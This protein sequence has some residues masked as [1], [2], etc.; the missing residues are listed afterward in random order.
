MKCHCRDH[1]MQLPVAL[2]VQSTSDTFGE[3]VRGLKEKHGLKYVLCWQAMAGYWSGCMPGSP[4]TAAFDPVIKFPR[5]SP[6]VLEVDPSLNWVHPAVVGVGVPRNQ[7]Q[8]H[9]DLHS[10]LA[11]CGVDGVKCDVQGTMAILGWDEGGY[12]AICSRFHRS[13]E[14]SVAKWLPGNHLLNSMCCR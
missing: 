10:Y 11:S 6:G 2:N 5:P 1:N 7:R 3:V 8:L 4:G 13:L 12:A 14:D 9:G